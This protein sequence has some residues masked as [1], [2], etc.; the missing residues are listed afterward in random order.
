MDMAGWSVNLTTLFL[1]RLRPPK[2]LTCTLCTV[3]FL[4]Q[5]K[6]KRVCSQTR[7]LNPGPLALESDVLLTA[8]CGP[9]FSNVLYCKTLADFAEKNV[10]AWSCKSFSHFF[11]KKY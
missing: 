4:N 5:W 6:E 7:V 8:P 10:S 3:P 11:S 2:R 1:G 9:A